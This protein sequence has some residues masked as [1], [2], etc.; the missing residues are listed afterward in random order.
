MGSVKTRNSRFVMEKKRLRTIWW[1]VIAVYLLCIYAT[2]GIAPRVWDSLDAFM[3][4]KAMILVYI[5]AA[6]SF[7]ALVAFMVFVKKE[8]LPDRYFMLLIF[9]AIFF[10]LNLLAVRPVEKVHL[11][12][13]GG[14]SFLLYNALKV[15]FDRFDVKLYLLGGV[16]C[17]AAGFLDE[18]I[19]LFLPGR[20]FDWRDV[21]F[22]G[23]SGITAFLVIRFNIL[24][25]PPKSFTTRR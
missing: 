8:K 6:L 25:E 19:Q 4:G 1:G 14:L 22:N 15:D 23:A 21:L 9:V 12:E 16:V 24:K 5:P 18:V 13:Y 17:V 2:L 10:E 3:G 7:I 11:L 20:F